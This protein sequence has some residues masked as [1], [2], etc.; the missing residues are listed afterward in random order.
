MIL[1]FCWV[2]LWTIDNVVR[3]YRGYRGVSVHVDSGT[4]RGNCAEIVR[5]IKVRMSDRRTSGRRG[6]EEGDSVTGSKCTINWRSNETVTQAKNI[7]NPKYK[8]PI[9]RTLNIFLFSKAKD[10]CNFASPKW[11]CPFNCST[12]SAASTRSWECVHCGTRY[13]WLVSVTNTRLLNRLYLNRRCLLPAL[14]SST[15]PQPSP[16]PLCTSL[17]WVNLISR[18]LEL[19]CPHSSSEYFAGIL[20]MM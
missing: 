19:R 15:P 3:Y 20:L 13:K 16:G 9:L 14:E 8:D 5:K 1:W 17:R 18:V 6:W 2:F 10:L 12:I 4:G 7:V 11:I